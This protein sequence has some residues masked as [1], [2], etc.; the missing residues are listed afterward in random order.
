[1]VSV[2]TGRN[3]LLGACA[4]STYCVLESFLSA[5]RLPEGQRAPAAWVVKNIRGQELARVRVVARVVLVVQTLANI[6]QLAIP[7]AAL[8]LST[9][10][11]PDVTIYSALISGYQIADALKVL[12]CTAVADP[13]GRYTPIPTYELEAA[14]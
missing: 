4:T 2:L 12:C 1:V 8:Y 6:I 10:F 7:L 14:E 5:L 13:A 9:V 11:L 3:L